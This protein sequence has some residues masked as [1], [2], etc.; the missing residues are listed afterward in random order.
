M[1]EMATETMSAGDGFTVDPI[2]RLTRD[3]K[4]AAASLSVDEV[5]YLVDMYYQIQRDRIRAGNQT[6]SME[7]S[8]EPHSLVRWLGDNTAVLENNI[9]RA[10]DAYSLSRPVG[11]WARSIIGVG[12]VIAS[13]LLAH[14]D[15]VKAQTVGA[16]WRFA[17]LDPTQKWLGAVGAKQRTTELWKTLDVDAAVLQLSREIGTRCETLVHFATVGRDGTVHKMTKERLAKAAARRPWNARLKVL[18]WKLGES[19]KKTSGHE[20]SI[21]GKLYKERKRIEVERNEAGAFAALAKATLE[22][23][24]F[25]DSETKTRYEAGM[26]PDGRLDL[27]AMRYAVK[28]FLAHYHHVAYVT[29]FQKEPPKPY[30]FTEHAE[31]MHA[32]YIAPP[33]WPLE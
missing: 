26:L 24:T 13:G 33:N 10:L 17:G 3:L 20:D 22:A 23:K 5:R 19:F 31:T 6:S 29:H 7:E 11:R 9:K 25:R 27:R 30:I 14:V 16:I 28:L 32:H 8:G 15:I 18:C 12:P 1:R 4:T 2:I 21:Y